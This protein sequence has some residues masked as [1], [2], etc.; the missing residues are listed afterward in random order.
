MN[1]NEV[2]ELK[3]ELNDQI[4]QLPETIA[5]A[6]R[7]LK[8]ETAKLE[9]LLAMQSC[10]ERVEDLKMNLL[11]K[12]R[13]EIK[14]LESDR[15]AAQEKAKQSE[16]S[17][18]EP[19]EKKEIA[20]RMIGDMSILDEA[21]RDVEQARKDLEPLKQSL[22]PSDSPND[23][24]LDGLQKKRKELT[25][26]MKVLDKKIEQSEKRVQE[27]TKAITS[28]QDKLLELKTRELQ[29]QGD[30]QKV[31]AAKAREKELRDEIKELNEKKA[32]SD[33][34]LIPIEG[35]IKNAVEKRRRTKAEGAEEYKNAMKKFDE[36]KKEFDS[37]E[38]VTKELDKLALL[39]LGKEINRYEKLLE[40]TN[41]E[42]KEKVTPHLK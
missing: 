23:N 36:L 34:I 20:N 37:I 41:N 42:K 31:D 32:T 17:V 8:R 35:K 15:S 9:K 11:P 1:N 21:I 12:L 5:N 2:D 27:D 39:S 3:T 29:L 10:V 24:N 14:K 19:S 25:D 38:R 18:K 13:D 40:Q 30:S 26:K 28:L 33:Q 22:P 16:R 7:Q 4:D 6:E